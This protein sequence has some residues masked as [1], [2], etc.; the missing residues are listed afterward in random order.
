MWKRLAAWAFGVVAVTSWLSLLAPAVRF[1]QKSNVGGLLAELIQPNNAVY[2][3]DEFYGWAFLA[4][5]AVSVAVLVAATR[6]VIRYVDESFSSITVL[7][8]YLRL[9]IPDD[10][11][12]SARLSRV[13]SFHANRSGISAYKYV[14]TLDTAAG[15]IDL[16]SVRI[17]SS[18]GLHPISNPTPLIWGTSKRVEVI[19][20]FNRCLPTNIAASLFP[21]WLTRALWKVGFFQRL[22]VRRAGDVL[23]L[24]EHNGPQASMAIKASHLTADLRIEISFP[25]R[26]APADKHINCMLVRENVVERMGFT[27]SHKNGRVTIAAGAKNFRN[28]ELRIQWR[29]RRLEKYLQ[30]PRNAKRSPKPEP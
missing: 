5:T 8:A 29:N 26:T 14:S 17:S 27:R 23:Y 6:A 4:L 16:G 2:P 13:Q 25:E 24:N 9:E 12:A 15:H 21:S 1:L 11:M 22:V 3:D 19:E 10:D 18:L 20:T 28:E 30:Q 7:D